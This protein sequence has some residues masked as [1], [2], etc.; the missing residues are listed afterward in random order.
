MPYPP[1]ILIVDDDRATL[2]AMSEALRLKLGTLSIDTAGS[3]AMAVT[4]LERSLYDLVICD[5]R[6]P[7]GDGLLVLKQAR[8]LQPQCPV[9]LM[10]AGGSDAEHLAMLQGAY[11]FIEKPIDLDRFITMVQVALHAPHGNATPQTGKG[12]RPT[13]PSLKRA[14]RSTAF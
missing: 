9:A 5:V 13:G 7:N 3:A 12:K 4:L 2:L 6:M 10:T 14:R 8:R 1:C 11:A